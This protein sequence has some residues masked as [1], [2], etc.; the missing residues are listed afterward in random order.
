M[1]AQAQYSANKQCLEINPPSLQHRV[2][3]IWPIL[4]MKLRVTL[5]VRP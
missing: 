5:N 4:G 1:R 2:E 3:Y